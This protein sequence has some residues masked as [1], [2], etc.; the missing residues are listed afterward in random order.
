MVSN[1]PSSERPDAKGESQPSHQAFA[2][3]VG[4]ADPPSPSGAPLQPLALPDSKPVDK[5]A[6]IGVDGE[7]L[8][9][10]DEPTLPGRLKTLLIGKPR[11][12][13]DQ[14]VFK[15]ISL[16]AFLAWVGLGADG[17]SSSCYGPAEAFDQLGE[18]RYLAFFLALAIG[19]TVFIIS[20]CYSH[21]IEAFPSGGGGYLV[22]SKLLGKQIGVISGSALLVDYVMTI[23]V[24]IAAAGDALFGLM[25][26][27][28]SEW[29]IYAEGTAIVV[30]I[31]LNLRGVKESVQILMPIFLLFLLTHFLLIGGAVSM[32]LSAAGDVAH[33]IASGITA[34][35][36]SPSF[37]FFAM[38]ACF[39]RAYSLGAGTY[40]GL[41][42]VSNSMPVMREPRV[43]T[44]KRTMRYMAWSLAITAGG[45]IFAYL[46][47]NIRPV[48][49]KTLN[50]VLAETLVGDLGF[51]GHWLGITFVL[52]AMISEG[53]LLIVAAQAGFIDGPRVLANMAH[54]SWMPRWFSNL[55]E[56]LA[57]HNGVLLMGLTALAALLL[58]H[59]NVH[60]LIVM[61]SINV[62][63]T[64][65]LSMIGM[66]R[67]WF[68][69]RGENPLWRRRLALFATGA[70]LCLSILGVSLYEKVYWMFRYEND[71]GGLV[72]VAVTT[73][74]VVVCFL[75]H[76]YYRRVGASLQH[77]NETL[78]RL[79]TSG[80]PNLAEPDPYLPAAVILVGDYGGLGIHTML[81][82]V[83]FAPGHFKSFIFV[84]VGVI[85]SGNFKGTGAVEQLREHCED[86][87]RQYVE[88]G[89]RLG[90][91]ST[92][93]LSIGTDAVDELEQACLEVVHKFPKATFFAGQLVF[94]KDTWLHR[95][96]HNQTAVSL[97]R[98]M[99]WAGVPMVILPTRV[100]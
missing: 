17:L 19:G 37:G 2:D 64:F 58:T 56:R 29:K 60:T 62:F 24:S 65:S 82:A 12:L 87:L 69:L 23:T 51:K 26:C 10:G 53:T 49:D 38:L 14:S 11:D 93:V 77:L 74:C 4:D 80:E 78:G 84:S 83:R 40:T 41:E 95:F 22:A 94:Q 88:L 48:S 21:I 76:G 70:V 15:H 5:D 67:H 89:Q 13:Q 86:S 72:T 3:S 36:A 66:C 92:S 79:P 47:L 54:D 34:D 55:S 9:E 73:G 97:Q 43:D 99:Q 16:V 27:Y 63:V 18:H 61:Y 8:S 90:M 32:H 42:A 91:P 98:R 35:V 75:V 20:S 46:L 100:R 33:N 71:Y 57:T 30:L 44:A 31:V 68:S 28:S 85:D 7:P 39:L 1:N 50:Q 45:L 6:V 96:L 52:A 25:G 81:N 59:G